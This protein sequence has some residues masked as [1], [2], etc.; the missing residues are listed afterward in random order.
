MPGEVDS[1][2]HEIQ[3][4]SIVH[5]FTLISSIGVMV[6][7]VSISQNV[8]E[9]L[10]AIGIENLVGFSEPL[11]AKVYELAEHVT[12]RKPFRVGYSD[13]PLQ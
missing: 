1:P 2:L 8:I 7:P 6:E 13:K 3:E 5:D 9:F 4:L 12:R 10:R 11:L